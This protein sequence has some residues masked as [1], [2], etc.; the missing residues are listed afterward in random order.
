LMNNLTKESE[1]LEG[2]TTNIQNLLA[3]SEEGVATIE[4]ISSSI[5]KFLTELKVIL[6]D[7][8]KVEKYIKIFDE[9]TS[10]FKV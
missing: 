7:V 8:T 5:Q 1:K 3:I 4:E 2:T 6:E 10:T 9:R